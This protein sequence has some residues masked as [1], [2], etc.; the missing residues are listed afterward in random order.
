MGRA[1]RRQVEHSIIEGAGHL[2]P[3]T[4]PAELT[5]TLGAAVTKASRSSI[6]EH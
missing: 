2:M 1:L 3:L 5:R 4:H 6:V